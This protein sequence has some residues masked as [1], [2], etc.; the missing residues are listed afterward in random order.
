MTN[1]SLEEQDEKKIVGSGEGIKTTEKT[2]IIQPETPVANQPQEK[3]TEIQ[4]KI[5]TVY[6]LIN[7]SKSNAKETLNPY[8]KYQKVVDD[9]RKN[10]K[11]DAFLEQYRKRDNLQMPELPKITKLQPNSINNNSNVVFD[12]NADENNLG[13][14]DVTTELPKLTVPQ[15]TKIITD[16]F[17]KSTV[18][19]PSDAQG[20]YNAQNTSGMSALAILGIG[21]L[22]SGYGTSALA[23]QKNNL[24]GWAAYNDDPL[25]NGATFSPISKGASDF[26]NDYIKTYYNN[27]GAKSINSAGT[28]NN[29]AKKGYSYRSDGSIE[30]EWASK[31]NSIM[32]TFYNT[33]K[34]AM[35]T[36]TTSSTSKTTTQQKTTQQKT[37]T[38][39]KIANAAQKYL[40]TP[41]VWGGESMAEGGMDC[42]GFVYNALKDAGYK[43]GRDTAQGYRSVGKVVAKSEMQPG[44][45][46]FYGKNK[47]NATH[48][49]I[50]LGDGKMIHSSGGSNNT[51]TNPGKGVT[52]ANV[53]Y[54]SD[55]I[56]ARRY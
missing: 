26:A 15:I 50:Y 49:A 34:S 31:V 19:K 8:D 40:G 55:F 22:E 27:Y 20:I 47:N 32:K 7:P 42:S 45:L 9:Y 41:Y 18:I 43:V 48:I 37:N 5:D 38:N 21:A 1:Y 33:A 39:N 30:S 3:K 16:H 23:T 54:R 12:A 11:V 46:I 35:P 44:D 28:G 4:K 52:I 53:D 51:K 25:G 24:W 10:Q 14:L 36:T 29:P 2:A 56:E 13:A 17:S 6:G